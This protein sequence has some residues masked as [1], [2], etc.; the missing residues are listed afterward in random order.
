MFARKISIQ[1]KPNML[2]EFTRTFEKEIVPLLHKQQGFKGEITFATS[3][4][5]DVLAISLWDTQKS[6]DLYNNKAYKDV[7]QMLANVVEGTPKVETAEVLHSTFEEISVA[8][9]IAA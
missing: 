8:K 5:R 3:G 1:V 4:S 2:A 7:L 6:A 9:P